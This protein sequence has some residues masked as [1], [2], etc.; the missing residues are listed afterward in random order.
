MAESV[1]GN[2]AMRK[3]VIKSR[4][5]LQHTK[6]PRS[7]SNF[8]MKNRGYGCEMIIDQIYTLVTHKLTI[9]GEM[10]QLTHKLSLYVS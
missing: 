9:C 7:L 5:S 2:T 10:N 3:M 4:G 8:P 6:L 1:T